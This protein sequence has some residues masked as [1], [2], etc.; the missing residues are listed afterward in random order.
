MYHST[1]KDRLVRSRSSRVSAV[2]PTTCSLRSRA[3]LQALGLH[4]GA[5][6]DPAAEQ[7]RP[8]AQA[9]PAVQG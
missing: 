6:L 9:V 2:S 8:G 4:E 3:S 7:A 1:R 5:Q